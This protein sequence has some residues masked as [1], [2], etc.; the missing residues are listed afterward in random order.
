MAKNLV[1]QISVL[2]N[3]APEAIASKSTAF[4]PEDFDSYVMQTYGRFSLALER[5]QGCRVWD[6]QGKEYLD[7]VAGIATCTLGHAHPALIEAITSQIQTLHHVSNLYYIPVQGELAKWLVNHSCAD[8]VFFCNSGAEANEGAIKLARKYAHTVLGITEPIILTAHASFH[9]RTLATI[10]ATGQPKYQKN[11]DPLVPGFHYVPYNDITAI[12][13]AITELDAS[14]KRVTAILLEPLQGEGGVNPGDPAYFQKIRQLCDEQGILLILDEVQVGMGRTGKLWGYENLGIEP[15]IFTSAK[16]LGGGIPI[17]A[18][19]CKHHCDVFQPGDHASTFGGNPLVC[20]VALAV[21]QTIE[22][23]NLLAN[24]QARGEQLRT[25]L[26]AVAAKFPLQIANAR[27][28]GLINGLQLVEDS[29]ITAIEIVKA[30]MA[31]GLLL[32][33]AGPKVVRFVPPLIVSQA[34]IETALHKLEQAIASLA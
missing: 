20:A 1:E 21:C 8:K 26:Q 29:P 4:N 27:G 24:A 17:G 23:E 10:T 34:E 16:G 11:F 3:K 6:T 28:W 33:P 30:A 22:T 31:E 18:T 5:G 2:E 13:S 7:F 12:E 19:L 14:E 25:G 9:G 15:D 32:V